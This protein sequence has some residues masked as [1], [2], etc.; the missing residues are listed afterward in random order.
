MDIWDHFTYINSPAVIDHLGM[1]HYNTEKEGNT[2]GR[3]PVWEHRQRKVPAAQAQVL[4]LLV[5]ESCP[6]LCDHLKL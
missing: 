6:I 1:G 5:I 4:L 3:K 2:K